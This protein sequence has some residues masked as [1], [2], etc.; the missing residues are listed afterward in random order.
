MR[1]EVRDAEARHRLA[2]ERVGQFR[3]MPPI[4]AHRSQRRRQTPTR[5][6]GH[7][8]DRKPIWSRG[9]RYQIF[10]N[11]GPSEQAL[12]TCSEWSLRGASEGHRIVVEIAEQFFEPA[13]S[14]TA[15]SRHGA[16]RISS[17][18]TVHGCEALCDTLP[19]G[20]KRLATTQCIR[21]LQKTVL[22]PLFSVIWR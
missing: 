1:R 21:R 7:D 18:R 11:F 13:N 17:P 9:T 16:G 14:G 6:G 22:P 12:T 19:T 8:F 5:R 15:G 4:K 20:S 2:S 10:A 3:K